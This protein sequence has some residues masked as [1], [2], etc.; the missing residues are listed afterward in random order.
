M[1]RECP[2]YSGAASVA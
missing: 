1:P 2:N